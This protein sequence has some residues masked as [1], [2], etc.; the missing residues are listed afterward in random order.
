MGEL[1]MNNIYAET[2]MSDDF[3]IVDFLSEGVPVRCIRIKRR[4]TK[5]TLVKI[6]T[7]G[8]IDWQDAV[9]GI[10]WSEF[11]TTIIYQPPLSPEGENYVLI[12]GEPFEIRGNIRDGL[13]SSDLGG[14]AGKKREYHIMT[15]GDFKKTE[16]YPLYR[17]TKRK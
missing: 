8:R 6:N 13:F 14:A 12:E 11:E 10:R 7:D 15:M 17:E 5:R 1:K 2:G 4:A 9:R 3:E 16:L